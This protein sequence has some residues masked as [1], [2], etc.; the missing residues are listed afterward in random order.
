MAGIEDEEELAE[1]QLLKD[2]TIDA[3]SLLDLARYKYKETLLNYHYRSRY[4]E[5]ILFSNHA[6][7]ESKLIVSPNVETPKKP[8][9]DYVYVKDGNF[10]N[11]KMTLKQKKLSNYLKRF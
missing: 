5:L 4:E 1:D 10:I 6:F 11:K 2:V 3:K 9:I 8:P 7:Y